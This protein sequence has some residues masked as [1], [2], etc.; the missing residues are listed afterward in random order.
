MRVRRIEAIALLT[1]A[2]AAFLTPRDAF[3]GCLSGDGCDMAASA[4]AQLTPDPGCVSFEFDE[5]SCTC[6]NTLIV[7]NNCSP[8]LEAIG[9]EW[10]R[11]SYFEGCPTE[12]APGSFE[13]LY[14][15]RP[16]ADDGGDQTVELPLLLDADELTLTLTYEMVDVKTGCSIGGPGSGPTPWLSKVPLLLVAVLLSRRCMRARRQAAFRVTPEPKSR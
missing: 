16:G 11:Y 8:P 6:R 9:F 1:A 7:T 12:V 3:A 10:C 15:P 4:E 5:N 14:L 2:A 13:Y